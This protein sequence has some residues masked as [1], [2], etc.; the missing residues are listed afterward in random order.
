MRL[1]T[2]SHCANVIREDPPIYKDTKLGF[3]NQ[4]LN[5]ISKK[6]TRESPWVTWT[7]SV[8]GRSSS[9]SWKSPFGKPRDGLQLPALSALPRNKGSPRLY[10]CSKV[11]QWQCA[12]P[13]SV[14]SWQRLQ[15]SDPEI[16]KR[17]FRMTLFRL[18]YSSA[19]GR[20]CPGQPP[21]CG[22]L[23]EKRLLRPRPPRP[24]HSS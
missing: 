20:F 12:A 4:K 3:V 24:G 23:Q 19:S 21:F 13:H 11:F 17:V 16:Q 6:T 1:G 15:R 22:R 18:S 7:P 2:A 9:V 14:I 5:K 10:L 8:G